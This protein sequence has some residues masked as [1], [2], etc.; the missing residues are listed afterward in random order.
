MADGDADGQADH[1]T[2]QNR[3]G[4]EIGQD[5]QLE[6]TCY[7]QDDAGEDGQQH[8]DGD[9]VFRSGHHQA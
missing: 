4:E 7:E 6:Q 8:R 5:A 3:L 2:T 1:E 9:K